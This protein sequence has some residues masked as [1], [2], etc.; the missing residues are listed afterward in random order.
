MAMI[1]ALMFL[2]DGLASLL[3]RRKLPGAEVPR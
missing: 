2:P 1:L 3:K